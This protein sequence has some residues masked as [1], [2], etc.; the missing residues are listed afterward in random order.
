[1]LGRFGAGIAVALALTLPAAPPASAEVPVTTFSLENG[2]D[3]AVIED[4]RAPVVVQML[5]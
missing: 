5:W 4:H 3:V 2:L 1:M